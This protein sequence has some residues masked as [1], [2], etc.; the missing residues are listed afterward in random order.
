VAASLQTGKNSAASAL[1][2]SEDRLGS[3]D[4]EEEEEEEEEGGEEVAAAGGE[5]GEGATGWGAVK[6]VT[7]AA[8]DS[9]V[10]RGVHEIIHCPERL[11][12]TLIVPSML[13]MADDT[14]PEGCKCTPD[15]S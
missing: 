2:I 1:S 12:C 6:R 15:C 5:G 11:R 8:H 4:E 9:S 7:E 3:D 13:L 14:P 10:P